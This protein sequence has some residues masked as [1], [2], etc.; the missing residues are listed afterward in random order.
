VATGIN[1]VKADEGRRKNES[2]IEGKRALSPDRQ[3]VGYYTELPIF[4]SSARSSR[5]VKLGAGMA[6]H[7]WQ[8]RKSFP[9]GTSI[10][11]ISSPFQ[12]E[13]RIS[14][15]KTHLFSRGMKQC[16]S[17]APEFCTTAQVRF[18]QHRQ[19]TVDH[20]HFAKR[21]VL[22]CCNQGMNHE[23]QV[24]TGCFITG[25]KDYSVDR[26]LIL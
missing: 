7:R 15:M 24:S 21:M 1:Q 16:C 2:R 23:K 3:S 4:A 19:I 11:G 17:D 5:L 20:F 12:N 13:E 9:K 26:E 25:S 22:T 18:A 10:I 6:P 14:G 8:N